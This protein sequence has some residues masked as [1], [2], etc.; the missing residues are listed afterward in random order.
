MWRLAD[1]SSSKRPVVPPLHVQSAAR[2]F[3][4]ARTPRHRAA[5]R[6]PAGASQIVCVAGVGEGRDGKRRSAPIGSRR[7]R[8]GRKTLWRVE[9]RLHGETAGIQRS[10]ER[11]V[12]KEWITPYSAY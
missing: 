3:L 8:P 7:R 5:H 10:E 6:G 4:S 12:G 2:E 9:S 11:R 1:R